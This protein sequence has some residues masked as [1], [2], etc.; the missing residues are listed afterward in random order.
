MRMLFPWTLDINVAPVRSMFQK[1]ESSSQSAIDKNN[2]INN[3]ITD[4]IQNSVEKISAGNFT[5]I[6]KQDNTKQYTDIWTI[7]IVQFIKPLVNTIEPIIKNIHIIWLVIALL[8]FTRKITAYQSFVKY[9]YAGS[10][11]VD[12]INLLEHFGTVIEQNNIKGT[13]GLYVND[14]ISSPM[15]IGFF[16]PRIIL[17]TATLSS[18]S[19]FH[20][21]ILHELVHYKCMD[22]LYKWLVQI[23]ICLHWFNPFVYLIGREINRACELSCDE[24][25][26]KKL[27]SVAKREYGDT[28][29]EAI[30][31]GGSYKNIP[32][33]VTLNESKELL[34]GRLEAIMKYKEKSRFIK[35][36]TLI[37]TVLFCIGTATIGVYKTPVNVHGSLK[38]EASSSNGNIIYED[39]NYYVIDKGASESDK[40]SGFS[41]GGVGLTLVQKDGYVSLGTFSDITKLVDE[42]TRQCK[43]GRSFEKNK[44]KQYQYTMLIDAAEEIQSIGQS[45]QKCFPKLNKESIK[46]GKGGTFSL[47]MAR[48]SKKATW[49]SSNEKVATVNQ[50]GK[51]FAKKAGKV[52]IY[53]KIGRIIYKCKVKVKDNTIIYGANY[54]AK[55]GIAKKAGAYYYKGKRLRIFMDVRAD[56][57]FV[58]CNYDQN[59]TDDLRIRRSKD[60]SI[61][62]VEYINKKEAKKILND[63]DITDTMI[64]NS[65]TMTYT[66]KKEI[67]TYGKVSRLLKKELP[68][69]VA[70]IINSCSSKKWYVIKKKKCQ[71][72]YYNGLPRDYAFN[73]DIYSDSIKINISDIGMSTGNYVL[74]AVKHNMPLNVYYNNTRVSYELP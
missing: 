62:K 32:T 7:K 15:L 6:S 65:T 30:K 59:G 58:C 27:D 39:G 5:D 34:K 64:S 42:V 44:S 45:G 56:N 41:V 25:V 61:A 74:L 28:L 36:F 13:V 57:S 14:T 16:H 20:Y 48:T 8:L 50:D 11:M 52:K 66:D 69:N 18:K 37:L 31:T 40:P 1:I 2:T 10:T 54:Y 47:K 26:I 55:Y 68:N 46:L 17:T 60:N 38:N 70:K 4:N 3:T 22:M 35:I 33:S 51:V 49:I 29:L 53:A 73:L 43:K 19:H 12:D 72:I 9:I 21:T 23:V 71:Y 24:M 63:M 67:K